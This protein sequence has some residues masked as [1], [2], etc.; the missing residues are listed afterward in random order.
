MWAGRKLNTPSTRD[1]YTQNIQREQQ[2]D[3]ITGPNGRVLHVAKHEGSQ[4]ECGCCRNVIRV[5]SSSELLCIV[6][7]VVAPE[8]VFGSYRVLLLLIMNSNFQ[9]QVD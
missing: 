6:R 7:T 3:F 5:S 4:N 8:C 9:Q 1:L 2:A